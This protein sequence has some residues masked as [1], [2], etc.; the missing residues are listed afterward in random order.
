MKSIYFSTSVEL[1]SNF[2]VCKQKGG[3]DRGKPVEIVDSEVLLG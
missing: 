1:F 2:T 3:R